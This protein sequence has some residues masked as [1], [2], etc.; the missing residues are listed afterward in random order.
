MTGDKPDPRLR[1]PMQWTPKSGVGFTSG[2]PWESPQPDSLE[3]NVAA[4][5]ADPGSLLNLYRAL[6]H[7]RKTNVALARGKLVPL[8]AS[9]PRVAAYLRRAGDRAVLVLA[10]LG[11]G[12]VAGVTVRSDSGALGPGDY[13]AAGLLGAPDGAEFRVGGSGRIEE[14]A[15]VSRPLSPRESLVLEIGRRQ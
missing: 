3:V 5:D 13:A 1:T 15:P 6:I 2:T 7:L 14:Y 11:G 12:P 9:D 4:Q 8:H 10:N